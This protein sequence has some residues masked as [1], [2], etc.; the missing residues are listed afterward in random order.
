MSDYLVREI[1]ASPRIT[2]RR[3]T[4]VVGADGRGRLE[5]LVLRDNLTGSTEAFAADALFVMIGAEPR[6]DWLD[7]VVARDPA[8]YV[9]TGADHPPGG[10]AAGAAAG[11]PGDQPP[12]CVRGRRRPAR[13]DETRCHVGRFGCH[14]G[15]LVHQYLA[16][17]P[18]D[19]VPG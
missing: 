13:F 8:G 12:R 17:L 16:D 6:T 3:S 11:V 5:S 7:G 1:D 2:L 4:E 18:E 9:L 14:G 19:A 10:L 15:R